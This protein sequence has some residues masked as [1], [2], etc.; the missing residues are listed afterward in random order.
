MNRESKPSPLIRY[1]SSTQMA[2]LAIPTP[3]PAPNASWAKSIQEMPSAVALPFMMLSIRAVSMYANGSLLPLSIS[4]IGAVLFLRPSFLDLR[5]EN[6]DAASVELTT[7]PSR[8]P[9]THPHRRA[10]WQN[11]PV[12]PAVRITPKEA[13]SDA[14]RAMGLAA[15]HLLPK[16]P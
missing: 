2:S 10:K 5:M 1:R 9:S 15:S 11:S 13:S 16:P 12:S 14:S 7:E 4:S 6:T 8:K 3:H